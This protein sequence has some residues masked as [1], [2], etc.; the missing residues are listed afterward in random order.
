MRILV[1]SNMYPPHHIGG[2]ELSCKDV[3]DRLRARGHEITILTTTMR[4]H[5]VAD[6]PDERAHGILRDLSFYWDDHKLVSPPL[7]E[8]LAR[9]RA[10]QRMLLDALETSRP[11]VVSIWNMGAMSLGLLT[12]LVERQLPMLLAV[13]DD[14][15]VYGPKL[16]AWTRLFKWSRGVA[17]AARGL[18]GV[19]TAIP[20]LD[21]AGAFCFVTDFVRRRA[22]RKARVKPRRSTVV[23]SGIDREDFPAAAP[24]PKPWDGRLLCVG[25]VNELKGVDVA[26]EALT[27]LPANTSVDIIGRAEPAYRA[28]LDEIINRL[29]VSDRIRFDVVERS[30]LPARYRAADALLFPV[31]W[32][33]PFGLVPIEAMACG[34]PV[35]ATGL[36]GSAE[37]LT[38]EGNCLLVPPNDPAALAAAITRLAGDGGLRARLVQGGLPLAD[39]LTTDRLADV[40]EVWHKAAAERFANGQPVDRSLPIAL[41]RNGKDETRL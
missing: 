18:F 9:E 24:E 40:F 37:F 26:I 15:L 33:E 39:E 23:Y 31:R 8:R 7:R 14:W 22:R 5:G 3:M 27:H 19:P 4:I 10:N 28:R 32:E 2:Y 38:D 36:G 21:D 1:L 30:D 16:D 12:T 25:R 29:G 35:V 6:P 17:R 41:R 13:C 20:A 34:T 11:D